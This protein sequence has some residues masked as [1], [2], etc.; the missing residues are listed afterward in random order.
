MKS[1]S[2]K[3]S[4]VPDEGYNMDIFIDR[5][6]TEYIYRQIYKH[7]KSLILNRKIKTGEKLPSKRKLAQDLDISINS[8]SNAYEQLLAEGYIYTKE[9]KG[10]YVEN[11]EKFINDNVADENQ[12]PDYLKEKKPYKNNWLSLSHINT[13]PSLFP[14]DKWMKYQQKAII[15]FKHNLAKI[16]H[17][18]G[19]YVVRRTIAEMVAK[20]RGVICEPEQIIIGTGT[21][22]LIQKLISTQPK[23]IKV[24]IE[25]PGYV[26]MFALLKKLNVNILP[27][28]LDSKGIDFKKIK[29]A[30][31]DFT[32]LTPSHQFPT[33]I[34]MPIS[35]RIEILNWISTRENQYIIEDDYDSEFKYGTDNI[36]SLQ[37]LDKSN[38]II[39]C[40]SFSKTLLPSF[41]ISYMILPP[42]LLELYQ[43]NYND[44]NENNSLNLYALHY[45]IKNGDYTKHIKKLNQ[46]YSKKREI[47]ITELQNRFKNNIQINDIPAGLH[48]VVSIFTKKT[49]NQILV[50]ANKR[51]LEIYTIERFILSEQKEQKNNH[52][53]KLVI[54]FASIDI[55]DIKKAVN[56]LYTIIY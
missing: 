53:V 28:S 36:P 56:E 11:L 37:G 54:G 39:Y 55:K 16:P 8:V 21:Q 6:D 52:E 34:I 17:Y 5:K 13:D 20:T 32:I 40:G 14:F 3:I 47:L 4:K 26:R 7:Y 10:Y 15:E 27:I 41:R 31:P 45:F 51:K 35:R 2:L 25:D 46:H 38:S 42:K 1:T 18:K 29:A 30:D 43:S 9:R 44:W 19:A 22:S 48:I 23:N 50:D 12:F 24:A 49:Y 33:G